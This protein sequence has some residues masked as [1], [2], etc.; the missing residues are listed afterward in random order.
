MS[1][2]HPGEDKEDHRVPKGGLDWQRH[3]VERGSS[4]SGHR[5]GDGTFNDETIKIQAASIYY[6]VPKTQGRGVVQQLFLAQRITGNPLDEAGRLRVFEVRS[7]NFYVQKGVV[8]LVSVSITQKL[9][10]YMSDLKRS[11]KY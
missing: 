7:L 5:F 9:A 8:A 6:R 4:F 1:R 3:R 10:L 11:G 2:S